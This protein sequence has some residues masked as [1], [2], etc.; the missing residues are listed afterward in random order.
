MGGSKS[1]NKSVKNAT[2]SNVNTS[3]SPRIMQRR[4]RVPGNYFVIWLSEQTGL[5]NEDNTRTL[6][7]LQKIVSNLYT[8]VKYDKCFDFI[9]EHEHEKVILILSTTIEKV[10]VRQIH[11]MPQIHSI[12]IYG[13]TTSSYASW[14]T[15][16]NKIQGIYKEIESICEAL[17]ETIWQSSQSD[18]LISC[19]GSYDEGVEPT[20]DELDPTF[21]YT[22]LLKQIILNTQNSKQAERDFIDFLRAENKMHDIRLKSIDKF[23][24]D[25]S[26]KNFIRWYSC[27]PL[28]YEL[29]NSSLRNFEAGKIIYRSKE[30]AVIKE[31]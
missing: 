17:R 12:Y 22:E 2:N 23:E 24:R 16:F 10:R 7:E 6:T 9:I 29:V 11:D 25:H 1:K 26:P 8:C 3:V 5:T 14:E 19:F 27:E 15:E 4:L 28:F 21:M 30:L 20:L 18:T 31:S 13:N